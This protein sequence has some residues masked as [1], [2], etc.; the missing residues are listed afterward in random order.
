[1]GTDHQGVFSVRPFFIVFLVVDITD[2]LSLTN[3]LVGCL[4]KLKGVL[5]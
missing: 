5:L 4:R 3:L 2:R 1:M